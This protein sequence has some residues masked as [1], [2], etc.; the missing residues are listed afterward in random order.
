MGFFRKLDNKI[1]HIHIKTLTK[2]CVELILST[3]WTLKHLHGGGAHLDEALEQLMTEGNYNVLKNEN[4]TDV[5]T[6]FSEFIFFYV[7]RRLGRDL[8]ILS[9]DSQVL[10]E[11]TDKYWQVIS[12]REPV[13]KSK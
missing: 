9:G 6:K 12:E 4:I 3:L 7:T 1:G 2:D 10:R 11:E 5:R 13:L 8:D